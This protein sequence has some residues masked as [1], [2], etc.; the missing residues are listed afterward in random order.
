VELSFG[1]NYCHLSMSRRKSASVRW[2]EQLQDLPSSP[3]AVQPTLQCLVCLEQNVRP[4]LDCRP[5]CRQPVCRTCLERHARSK[6]ELGV[7]RIDC[8]V[9]ACDSHVQVGELAR[10]D[11]QLAILYNRRLVDA[12]SDPHRKT[13]PNCGLV[14]ELSPS[15]LK[16]LDGRSA[17][18]LVISCTAC[19]FQWCFRCHCPQ[20]PRRRCDDNRANS[21]VLLHEWAQAQHEPGTPRAQQCPCCKVSTRLIP[22]VVFALFSI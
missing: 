18:K 4:E 2:M 8:P 12:N 10:L 7:V 6:L 13:C 1:R 9:P 21:D 14:T 17:R 3:V 5:C 11:P 20:H 22:A 15:Q 16:D 19:Q